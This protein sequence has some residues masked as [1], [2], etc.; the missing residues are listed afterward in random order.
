MR[1]RIA[2][3]FCKELTA[4]VASLRGQ[5]DSLRQQHA[6]TLNASVEASFKI[7]NAVASRGDHNLKAYVDDCFS[8]LFSVHGVH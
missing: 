5:L 6:L 3:Y 1:K 2:A 4:E 8:S 7:A